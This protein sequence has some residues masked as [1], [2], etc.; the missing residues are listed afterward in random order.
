MSHVTKAM[1][2]RKAVAKSSMKMK[3]SVTQTDGPPGSNSLRDIVGIHFDIIM[4]EPEP[5][6]MRLRVFVFVMLHVHLWGRCADI[7]LSW[8][9]I[10]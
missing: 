9:Y 8:H 6:A 2:E 10:K 3:F 1:A 7:A 5:P 4:P